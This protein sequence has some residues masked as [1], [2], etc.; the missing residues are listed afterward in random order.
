MHLTAHTIASSFFPLFCSR[1]GFDEI[2]ACYISGRHIRMFLSRLHY[3][4]LNA[5]E[6]EKEYLIVAAKVEN[7]IRQ[8]ISQLINM[9]VLPQSVESSTTVT[10]ALRP[11]PPDD[12]SQSYGSPFVPTREVLFAYTKALKHKIQSLGWDDII[13]RHNLFVSYVYLCMQFNFAYRSRITIPYSFDNFARYKHE[14]IADKLSAIY[15]EERLLPGSDLLH[16]LA[17]DIRN[18]FS[19]VTRIAREKPSKA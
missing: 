6:L 3:I 19:E 18:N 1:Y 9:K 16:D 8:N 7:K 11:I 13:T 17:C 12:S 2:M 4:H 10:T 5:Q 14:V 15:R